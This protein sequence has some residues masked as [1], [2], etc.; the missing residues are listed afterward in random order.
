MSEQL[1]TR[2]HFHL[3]DTLLG[4]AGANLALLNT[5]AFLGKESKQ[6]SDHRSETE[7]GALGRADLVSSTGAGKMGEDSLYFVGQY[8][9]GCY[10]SPPD[11]VKC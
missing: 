7:K 9:P 8:S 10:P 3:T 5:T 11:L 2:R 4:D 1:L 6:W